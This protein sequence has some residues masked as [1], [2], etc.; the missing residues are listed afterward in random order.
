MPESKQQGTQAPRRQYLTYP[1]DY[2]TGSQ[3]R[4]YFG[5]IF[6]DDIATIQF[7]TSHTK[8]PLYGYNDHQFR[9]VAKGQFIVRGQFTVAFKET[10]Y[11]RVI[12]D[13]IKNDNVGVA[14]ALRTD[15]SKDSTEK[16]MYYINQGLTIE[17]AI[18][19]A[20]EQGLSSQLAGA[21]TKTSDFEDIAEVLEDS[22][23]G[24]KETTPKRYEKRIPRSDEFDYF[25]HTQTE[26]NASNANDIDINGFDI[27]LTF[28]NYTRGLDEAEHTMIA[29]ND[30][31][32]TGES[33]VATPADE[34]IGCTYEFFA[35]GLNERVSAQWPKADQEVTIDAND[36]N[37]PPD[38]N[39]QNLNEYIP[40]LD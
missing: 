20:R 36:D 5:G 34:P 1:Q 16:F 33:L 2:Y 30:V 9:A 27:L 13:M 37:K 39:G 22:I 3:V 19:K 35:R 24:R 18:Q 7:Q 10:G 11:L 4:V 15:K 8:T 23:W 26:A 6:V 40:D 21:N 12:M 25:K 14:K 31:H 17:E 29:L 38:I 28:G 32:I